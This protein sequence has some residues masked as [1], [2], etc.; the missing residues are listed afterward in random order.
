MAMTSVIKLGFR[1]RTSFLSVDKVGS[2]RSWK[3][4]KIIPKLCRIY[5]VQ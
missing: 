5:E 3:A 4:Q 1:L 2:F